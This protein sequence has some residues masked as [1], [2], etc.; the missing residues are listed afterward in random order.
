MCLIKSVLQ[1][2]LLLSLLCRE[3]NGLIS[4]CTAKSAPSDLCNEYY[5]VS[6][7]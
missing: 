2:L 6:E 5:F 7:P 3:I 4:E 1:G